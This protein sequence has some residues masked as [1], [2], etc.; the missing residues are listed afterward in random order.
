MKTPLLGGLPALLLVI[1]AAPV[2]SAP[3]A[4]TIS[5]ITTFDIGTG[6]STT[7]FSINSRGDIAGYYTDSGVTFYR[8]F[9][10]LANGTIRSPIIE[11]NDNG[12]YTATFG[13]NTSQTM[14]GEFLNINGDYSA[15]HG[16]FL[17]HNTYTQYD[18]NINGFSTAVY[19]IN[20]AGDFSG[21]Y[22]NAAQPDQ[23]FVN[24]GG[25]LTT[26][27]VPGSFDTFASSINSTDQVAGYYDDE[28]FVPHGFFRDANGTLTYPIQP[29]GASYSLLIG[30]NDSGLMVGRY[31]DAN[32]V[33]AMIFKAP[34]KFISYDYPGAIETSFN[35]I[36]RRNMI[37]GRY[38]DSAG[39]RHGF[40]AQVSTN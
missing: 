9:L 10:R 17:S 14:T 12:N 26:F 38:T 6:N 34:R 3:N 25:V 33:H 4:I 8:G 39:L 19:G 40:L 20:D 32:G 5:I 15:Y 7:P 13:I 27:V 22:G 2:Y 16:F 11:P 18:V 1:A 28:S 21:A 37:T 23:G 30:I 24:I 29:V 31:S 35:G 36:N